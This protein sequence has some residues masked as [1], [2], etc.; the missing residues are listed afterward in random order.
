M[1]KLMGL[2]LGKDIAK[3]IDSVFVERL[4]PL[5]NIRCLRLPLLACSVDVSCR[6]G[7][8]GRRRPSALDLLNL[9]LR[10]FKIFPHRC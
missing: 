3:M 1:V 7:D 10:I 6:I 9:S 4:K 8:F 2:K 5:K